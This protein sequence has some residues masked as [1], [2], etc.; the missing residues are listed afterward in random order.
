MR[1]RSPQIEDRTQTIDWKLCTR[2][3]GRGSHGSCWRFGK[4]IKA[5]AHPA[6]A[7][8]IFDIAFPRQ[9]RELATCFSKFGKPGD[10]VARRRRL[11]GRWT[12]ALVFHGRIV[13]A[14]RVANL[15]TLVP[16]RLRGRGGSFGM[17]AAIRGKTFEGKADIG[18]ELLVEQVVGQEFLGGNPI[19]WVM[20]LL[21]AFHRASTTWWSS[22]PVSKPLW[23]TAGA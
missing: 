3:R 1:P 15:T 19:S 6:F 7:N 4:H 13:G 10:K 16:G 2:Y 8:G 11:G 23:S 14:A 22:S 9:R 21:R 18:G 5:F 20:L 12:A 17:A